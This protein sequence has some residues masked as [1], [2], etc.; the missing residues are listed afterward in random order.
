MGVE[1]VVL[2]MVWVLNELVRWIGSLN[3]ITVTIMD[4]RTSTFG[5]EW[6][7]LQVHEQQAERHKKS[8]LQKS[9]VFAARAAEL[10]IEEMV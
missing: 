6:R 4:E 3:K 2:W 9:L 10:A 8:L 1:T 7:R 5:H